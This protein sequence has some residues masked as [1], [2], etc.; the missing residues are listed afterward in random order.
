MAV[1]CDRRNTGQP[2][3]VVESDV[4]NS[5]MDVH[6]SSS[7]LSEA[8]VAL[9][10]S[11]VIEAA[12]STLKSDQHIEIPNYPD[13]KS[14]NKKWESPPLRTNGGYRYTLVVRPNGLK[15]TEGYNECIGIWL[16]P[17]PG[18]DDD[19]LDWPARVKMALRV[20]NF[21]SDGDSEGDANLLVPMDKY[22]WQRGDTKSRYPVFRFP[23]TIKHTAVEKA[24][25]V[26]ERT[27]Y[28]VVEEEDDDGG[29]GGSPMLH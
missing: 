12:L 7:S 28:I 18:E 29:G 14:K 21:T 15:F 17:M 22:T 4:T 5:S 9:F 23:A 6:S 1:K 8:D 20:K 16:K 24:K 3:V 26:V 2:E 10:F 25:C 11:E 27:L 19:E 13:L